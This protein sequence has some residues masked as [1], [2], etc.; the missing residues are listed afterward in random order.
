MSDNDID[1]SAKLNARDKVAIGLIA[2]MALGF[3]MTLVGLVCGCSVYKHGGT[4]LVVGEQMVL[5]ELTE[6]NSE[7]NIRVYES[8]KG[9]RVWARAN[10]R[11]RVEYLN[12]YTN[13]YFGIVTTRDEMRLRVEVEPSVTN[14]LEFLAQP[15]PPKGAD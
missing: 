15:Q 10:S 9:A 11:T 8:I 5:P 1:F 4:S 6:P 3:V 7:C 2:L 13:D 12:T 14:D